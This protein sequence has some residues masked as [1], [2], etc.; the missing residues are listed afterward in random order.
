MCPT[1]WVTCK[2]QGTGTLPRDGHPGSAS[3]QVNRAGG[4]AAASSLSK[5]RRVPGGSGGDLFI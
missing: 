5:S 4:D 2:Q 1:T 3:V